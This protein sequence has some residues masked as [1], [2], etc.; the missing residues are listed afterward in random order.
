MKVLHV[1]APVAFGGGESL[2]VNL[3]SERRPDLD[4]TV[5][6]V[7]HSPEFERRLREI[8]IRTWVLRSTSIGDGIS[9]RRV[10]A[11]T[12]INLCLA[13]RLRQVV[14]EAAAEIVHVHGYPGSLLYYLLAAVTNVRGIYT[15]HSVRQQPSVVEHAI[16][17]RCYRSFDSRTA[18][19]NVVRDS[20]NRAFFRGGDGFARLSTV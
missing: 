19:S 15:H 5:V 18:V 4:E 12:I 11:E 14:K 16:L 10:L 20:M 1:I 9:R 7:Y 3:L 6:A 2:L 8:G 13:P 17:G